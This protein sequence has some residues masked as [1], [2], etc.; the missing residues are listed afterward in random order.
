MPRPNTKKGVQKFSG[1]A[2]LCPIWIPDFSKITKNPLSGNPTGPY[3]RLASETAQTSSEAPG[4]SERQNLD[5]DPAGG[6]G[7]EGL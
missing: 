7:A 2:G 6:L 5:R 3:V 4:S 1:A